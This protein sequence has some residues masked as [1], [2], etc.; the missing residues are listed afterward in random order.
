MEVVHK[1]YISFTIV[2]E[3]VPIFIA[4]TAYGRSTV[5]EIN[6]RYYHLDGE[7]STISAAIYAWQEVYDFDLSAEELHEIM[8]ENK[9][10]SDAI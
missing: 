3:E 7:L 1:D 6:G 5:A 10:I 9:L 4:D 2:G 8:L